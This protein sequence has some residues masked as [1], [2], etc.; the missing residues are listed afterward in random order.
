VVGVAVDV[1]NRDLGREAGRDPRLADHAAPVIHAPATHHLADRGQVAQ[2]QRQVALTGALT[3]RASSPAMGADAEWG[4]QLAR[5]EVRQRLPDRALDHRAGEER[6][7]GVVH[8]R[9]AGRRPRRHRQREREPV[10]AGV[11]PV[12]VAGRR[13]VGVV[14]GKARAHGQDVGEREPRVRLGRRAEQ[15]RQPRVDAGDAPALD[16]EADQQ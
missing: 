6:G 5:G 3:A 9:L 14:G 2:A 16:G 8:I 4:E 7:E 12:L 1:A 10:V 11:E 15:R 13:R